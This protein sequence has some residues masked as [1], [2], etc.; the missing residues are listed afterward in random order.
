[1]KTAAIIL[2]AGASRR[3]GFPKQL[4]RLD[5]VSLVRKVA[6]SLCDAGVDKIGVVTGAW[7][8]ELEK[9]L[10]G[11]DVEVVHNENWKKGIASSISC[12]AAWAEEIEDIDQT[13]FLATDQ[14]KLTSEDIMSLIGENEK[15]SAEVIAASYNGSWGMPLL[16]G[17][18][19]VLSSLKFLEPGA[20]FIP[21]MESKCSEV[22]AV[23]MENA[24]NDLDTPAQ[25][26]ELSEF[27][28]VTV[29]RPGSLG[30]I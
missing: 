22:V 12:G 6:L 7:H 11:L 5:G 3:L 18:S 29:L 16:V 20:A 15:D 27:F 17:C 25:L 2:A 8:S 21:Y 19:N 24:S 14:W 13:I 23:P 9:E 26:M 30:A 28:D 4:V 10:A 1:M